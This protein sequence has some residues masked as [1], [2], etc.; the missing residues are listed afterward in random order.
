MCRGCNLCV[1]VHVVAKSEDVVP[2]CNRVKAESSW[3]MKCMDCSAGSHGHL[4]FNLWL[5]V[6]VVAKKDYVIPEGNRVK[7]EDS[8]RIARK[9]EFP[10]RAQ[11]RMQFER[12]VAAAPVSA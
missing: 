8:R 2:E 10:P 12:D 6:H 9:K 7:T 1:E 4:L 5:Q 11:L 3:R